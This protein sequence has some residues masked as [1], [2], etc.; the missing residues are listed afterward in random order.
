MAAVSLE[1][2]KLK[3]NKRHEPKLD[4]IAIMAVNIPQ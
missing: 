3:T 1:Y 2:K 4:N